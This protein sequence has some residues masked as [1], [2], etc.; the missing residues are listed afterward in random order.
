MDGTQWEFHRLVETKIKKSYGSN[1]FPPVYEE[2][3][4][5]LNRILY[6]INKK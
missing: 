4:M 3:Q 6:G 2:L 1:D 5:L